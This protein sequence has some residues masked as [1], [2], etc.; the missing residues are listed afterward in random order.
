MNKPVIIGW[1]LML[2]GTALWLYGYFTTGHPS[3]IEWRADSPWWIAE[4]LPNVE[5]EIGM[6]VMLIGMVPIYW[7]VSGNNQ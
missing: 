6:A 1:A 3:L 2:A 7:P 4:F 5:S